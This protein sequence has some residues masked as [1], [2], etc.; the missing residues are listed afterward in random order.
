VLRPIIGFPFDTTL[1]ANLLGSIDRAVS[2]IGSLDISDADK[3][4]IFSG[5]AHAI[6]N[7][8]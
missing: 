1:A 8:L 6:L 2:S 7:N 3:E 5:T 4:R